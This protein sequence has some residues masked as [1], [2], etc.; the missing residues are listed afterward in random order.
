MSDSLQTHGLS[1]TRLLCPWDFLHQGHWS[2]PPPGGHPNSRWKLCLPRWQG[3]LYRC[4]AWNSHWGRYHFT[5]NWRTEEI[6][7]CFLHFWLIFYASLQHGQSFKLIKHQTQLEMFWGVHF[8][9]SRDELFF[10]KRKMRLTLLGKFVGPSALTRA[11]VEA[12][13]F[14]M[15][16]VSNREPFLEHSP[17]QIFII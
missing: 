14:R 8:K 17:L 12:G 6:Q 16:H 9:E 13:T 3:S 10:L 1:P 11:I 4:R 5:H 2:G 7:K 15:C